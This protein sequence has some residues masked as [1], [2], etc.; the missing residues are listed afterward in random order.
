MR[1]KT[2]KRRRRR[3]GRTESENEERK[4][5]KR[6]EGRAEADRVGRE[7]EQKREAARRQRLICSTVTAEHLHFLYA[8]SPL[9]MP[10]REV[11]NVLCSY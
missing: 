1:R 4:S 9:Q 10:L 3:K 11:S 7:G 6:G 2:K 5:R 8:N